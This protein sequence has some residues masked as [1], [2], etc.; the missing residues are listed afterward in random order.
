MTHQVDAHLIETR[1][2]SQALFSG[3]FLHAFQG[4]VVLPGQHPLHGVNAA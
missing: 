4:T 1:L 2:K 3:Y